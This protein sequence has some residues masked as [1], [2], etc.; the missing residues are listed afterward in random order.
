MDPKADKKL[1]IDLGS[2]CM[3]TDQWGIMT[4]CHADANYDIQTTDMGKRMFRYDICI[5]V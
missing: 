5:L 1:S 2:S 4:M 3:V